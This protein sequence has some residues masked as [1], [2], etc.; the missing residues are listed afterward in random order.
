MQLTNQQPKQLRILQHTATI[1]EL[2]A[3]SI[4]RECHVRQITFEKADLEQD[5]KTIADHSPENAP[6]VILNIVLELHNTAEYFGCELNTK[7]ELFAA[8]LFYEYGCMTP[9]DWLLFFRMVR[10]QKFKLSKY[11]SINRHG[12]NPEYVRQFLAEYI[13]LK[14]QNREGLHATAKEQVAR[15]FDTDYN[16]L[17][18][19]VTQAIA[20]SLEKGRKKRAMY[21]NMRKRTMIRTHHDAY[22]ILRWYYSHFDEVAFYDL[23]IAERKAQE[24]VSQM[25]GMDISNETAK[26]SILVK[27]RDFIRTELQRIDA[28]PI[29]SLLP[30]GVSEVSFRHKFNVDYD[31][32]LNT[33]ISEYSN[34]IPLSL[35]EYLYVTALFGLKRQDASK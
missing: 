3:G 27:T 6:I 15:D 25:E 26:H 11:D 22:A 29:G 1:L 20:D 14:L 33:M 35:H 7:P 23:A 19:E 12:I 8:D 16:T 5:C 30:K 10:T 4:E 2:Q 21:D 9:A 34:S 13:D 17:P 32:Y 31:E 28:T 18:Q 24:H